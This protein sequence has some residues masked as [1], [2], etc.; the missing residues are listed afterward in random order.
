MMKGSREET[1]MEELR[2]AT[3]PATDGPVF[4]NP[5]GWNLWWLTARTNAQ[6]REWVQVN[7]FNPP[8]NTTKEGYIRLLMAAIKNA[9][10]DYDTHPDVLAALK[11]ANREGEKYT[12]RYGF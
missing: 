11:A 7:G 1:Q 6:L 5:R 9:G 3:A 12:E 10:I 8:K 2:P 4:H